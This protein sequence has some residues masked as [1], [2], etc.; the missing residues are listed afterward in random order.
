MSFSAEYQDK[1]KSNRDLLERIGNLTG[2][3]EKHLAEEDTDS[4]ARTL[5]LRQLCIDE[6]VPGIPSF[7]DD[8]ELAREARERLT[9]ISNR[10]EALNRA[11][12]KKKSELRS[13][14]GTSSPPRKPLRYTKA[15][16]RQ[17]PRSILTV[18]NKSRKG[19]GRISD[20]VR[21]P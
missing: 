18:K 8:S 3:L 2:L 14:F 6:L 12:E 15:W 4:L 21:P 17:Y 16:G 20:A 11:V 13:V 5:R 10:S 7:E 19:S 9:D 1:L